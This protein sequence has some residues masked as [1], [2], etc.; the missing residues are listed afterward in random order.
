MPR[1]LDINLKYFKMKVAAMAD[2][3]MKFLLNVA[4]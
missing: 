4:D 1:C 2:D 3:G